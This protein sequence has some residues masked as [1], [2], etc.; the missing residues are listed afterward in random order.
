MIFVSV[1]AEVDFLT[2][3]AYT[4]FS[5]MTVCLSTSNSNCDATKCILVWYKYSYNM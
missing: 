1:Q 4:R 5:I 3:S 2:F